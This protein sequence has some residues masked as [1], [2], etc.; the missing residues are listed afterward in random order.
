MSTVKMNLLKK[1]FLHLLENI[2]DD[3]KEA[4]KMFEFLNN[5]LGF[6]E[7]TP[8]II[9]MMT[10]LKYQKPKLFYHV[11]NSVSPTSPKHIILQLETDY[12]IALQQLNFEDQLVFQ[13]DKLR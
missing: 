4:P 8:P 2:P 11:K 1:Q 13:K 5:L 6:K 3:P 12:E 9:E 7:T 10:I